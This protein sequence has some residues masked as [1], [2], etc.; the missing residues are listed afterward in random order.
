MAWKEKRESEKER[1]ERQVEAVGG[2]RWP[3]AAVGG[4]PSSVSPDRAFKR[5]RKK[6]RAL[7]GRDL[8]DGR[9]LRRKAP[10]GRRANADGLRKVEP[11]EPL[12]GSA[13]FFFE[14]NNRLFRFFSFFYFKLMK[15]ATQLPTQEIF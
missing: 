1:E 14:T 6:E 4:L 5:V 12:R 7:G 15:S 3:A 9:C 8:P 13:P 2:Q 11:A 10:D